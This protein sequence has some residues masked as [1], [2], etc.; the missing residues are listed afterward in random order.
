MVALQI[1]SKIIKTNDIGIILNNNL[2]AEHFFEYELEYEFIKNHYNEYQTVPNKET[3]LNEFN[4]LELIEV[5]EPDSYLVEKINEEYLYRQMVPII[6]ESANLLKTDSN[7]ASEYLLSNLQKL[8]SGCVIKFTDIISGANERFDFFEKK[9]ENPDKWFIATG[10]KEL[11]SI[12]NGWNCGEELGV[13]FARTGEGKSWVLV[14]TLTHSWK[15]GN[16]VG[17]ISPE[18]S[19]TK[20]GYRFDTIFKNF[21]NSGLSWA[22]DSLIEKSQYKTYIDDLSS[23]EG[24]IVS[25]PMDFGKKITVSKLKNYIKSNNLDILGIDGITYMTDERYKKG[26]NKTTSLTN[27]SEDLMSL[28]VE[29]GVP[30]LIVVQSNRGGVKDEADDGTPELENIRDS[31][32]IAQNA[33]KVIALRQTG[34]ALQFGIKKHRDGASGGKL[35]YHWNIDVGEFEYIPS[36]DDASNVSD[37]EEVKTQRKREFKDEKQVF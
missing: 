36:D 10:F 5:S 24:F 2:E 15:I 8:E 34:G 32:G 37:R 31:D 23:K 28:S 18:M 19:P 11:D 14:K 21:S 22:K 13:I 4:D 3:F 30:I 33:T 6:Q 9:L 20:I 16:R 7:I 17:Y 25:T 29:L 35:N 1:L 26:D 12:I 27:I